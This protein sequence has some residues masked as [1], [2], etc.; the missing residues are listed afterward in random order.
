MEKKLTGIF[1]FLLIFLLTGCREEPE[2]VAPEEQVLEEHATPKHR[3]E[4][5]I[6]LWNASDFSAMFDGYLDTRSKDAYGTE[7][8]IDWQNQLHE[9]LEVKNIEVSYTAPEEDAVWDSEIADVPVHVKMDTV[10]GPVE[11]D[12]TLTLVYEAQEETEDWFVAWDPSYIVPELQKGDTVHVTTS[13]AMRGEIVDRN[14]RPIAVNGVGYEI[15]VVPAN[16]AKKGELAELLGVTEDFIDDKLNQSWVQPGHYVP[17]ERIPGN[18]QKRLDRIFAIPGTVQKEVTMREYPY[19]AAL[20]HIS[21]FIGPITAEQLE[22]RKGQGY[23]TDDLIGRQGM[24]ETLEDRLRGQQGGRIEIEKARQGGERITALENEPVP[25]ETVALTIDADLQKATYD[26]MGYDAGTAA[27]VDPETGETLVLLSKPGFDPNEFVMGVSGSRFR[28]LANNPLKPMFNRF[29][30]T[31]APGSTIKPITAAIGLEAGTLDPEEGLTIDGKTWQRHSSWGGYR[32]TRLHDDVPNP[33]DLNKALVYSDNIYFAR[34]A[35]EI[36]RDGLVEGLEQF[37]FA[38]DIP[39]PLEL[40]PSQISGNGVLGSEGQLA[41]TS[42]GQGQMQTNI[43]HLASLYEVFLTDGI[44]YRPT[45]FMDEEDRQVWKEGLI[46]AEN[47]ERI[48]NSLRNAVTN[49]Y[50]QS[51]NLDDIPLAGKS[52]TAQVRGQNNGYFVAYHAENEDFILAMMIEDLKDDQD[53]D[54]VAAAVANVFKAIE[55]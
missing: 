40:T 37:G 41:D 2:Q 28:E 53:S 24:E 19:G 44:M 21:G 31:Y 27:A 9:Q 42:F 4:A 33:I 38:E 5:F 49:G 16:F 39:F 3:L 52:G 29:A 18:D 20:S 14:E 45:L 6:S 17:I 26:A 25:G 54:Y 12:K 48:R 51:A 30:A 7:T 1:F 23:E 47:A 8:F 22:E 11:F 35:M 10:I 50:S 55:K 32:V 15:G 46:S 13:D 43:L 36:G 34:Q